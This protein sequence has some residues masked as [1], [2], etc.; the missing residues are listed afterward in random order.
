MNDHV[1]KTIEL[2]GTSTNSIE[3][4]VQGAIARAGKTVREM[5]W[6]Q[7]TEIRGAV[8]DEKVV[9]WQVIVKASFRLE[10]PA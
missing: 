1:Y 7:V 9:Q 5:R 10:E 4:A 3:E 6:F 2:T 8:K